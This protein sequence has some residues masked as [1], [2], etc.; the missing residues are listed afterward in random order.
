MILAPAAPVSASVIWLHGLGADGHDF[1][2]IVPELKLP[3]SPGVRFVFPHAAI[4][5][6]TLNMGMRMRAWYD[7]KT[8]TAEGRTDE[9]GLRE[10]IARV[11]ALIAAERTFGIASERIVIAGFS[12]GGATALHAALRHPEPLAGVL[13]LSCYLPLQAALAAELADA[14]QAMPILMCHGQ[15]DPV[16]PI[17]LG[18]AAR[19]WLRAAGY[20]VEWKEYPMQHQVCLPEIQDIAAWLRTRF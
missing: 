12:Q 11:G 13:A 17:A 5:P 2:P 7:I 10:S 16:L 9:A 1:V 19:D 15:Q 8:L 4:R 18:R 6:V 14:N 3:P 20:R